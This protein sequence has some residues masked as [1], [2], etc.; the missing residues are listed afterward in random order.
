MDFVWF[1]LEDSGT[2]VDLLKHEKLLQR[3]V[4]NHSEFAEKLR[5]FLQPPGNFW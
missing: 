2:S 4:E 3:N 1:H 5:K